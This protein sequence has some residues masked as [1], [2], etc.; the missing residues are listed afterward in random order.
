ML[1]RVADNLYWLARYLERAENLARLVDVNANLMLDL[2]PDLAPGW[3]PLITITG[4][5]STYAELGRDTSE[6]SV[7]RFMIAD[8]KNRGSMV[9]TLASA[10]EIARTIRDILPREVWE[11]VNQHFL[12]VTDH[13]GEAMNKRTRH[14]FLERVVHGT[15]TFTGM[16]EGIVNDGPSLAFMALG[17]NLERAD[18]TSRI[19]DVRAVGMLP[20]SGTALRPFASIQWM[21]VLRS[22]SGYHMYR[23]KMRERVHP[24]GVVRFLLADSDFPRACVCCLKRMEIVLQDLPNSGNLLRRVGRVRNA[25]VGALSRKLSQDELHG[26]IDRLQLALARINDELAR[27]YFL[28]ELALARKGATAIA[29]TQSQNQAQDEAETELYE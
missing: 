16:L 15:Q 11:H 12:Y 8:E 20:G 2:P 14:G 1:S 18:M 7:V 27:T 24:N 23:L 25:V 9:A 21:S 6:R 28:G 19:V 3:Q 29:Q 26:F 13:A 22:L 17:R 5:E 10:R 4:A